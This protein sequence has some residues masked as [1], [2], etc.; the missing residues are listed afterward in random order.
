M[1]GLTRRRVLAATGVA[2]TGAIAGCLGGDDGS[3]EN[4]GGDD[5]VDNST[6]GADEQISG[7]D[8]SA[9]GEDETRTTALGDVSI[10][11]LDDSAHTIDVLVQFDNEIEHWSTHEIQADGEGV[12]LER[13]WPTTGGEFRLTVRLDGTQLTQVTPAEWN[14]P[15]CLN[16]LV[17]VTRDGTLSIPG[18]T[19]GGTCTAGSGDDE[20]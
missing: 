20:R 8:D 16:L 19:D 5:G 3:D 15:D 13:D 6:D 11:N 10:E 12:T 4:G 1:S 9:D 18:S 14:H 2:A 7:T 17:L